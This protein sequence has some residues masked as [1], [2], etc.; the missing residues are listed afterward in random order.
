MDD[1][2]EYSDKLADKLEKRIEKLYEEFTLEESFNLLSEEQQ[3]EA[4]FILQTFSDYMFSYH[5]ELE[6]DWSPD[7]VELCC[8]ETLPRKVSADESYYKAIVPVLDVF[9]E[10]LETK[11]VIS[12]SKDLRK[13]IKSV[14]KDIIRNAADPSCWGLAKGMVMRA[15]SQGYDMFDEDEMNEY[16]EQYNNSLNIPQVKP[17]RSPKKIGRN[18]PCI[19]GSGTKYK[20]CCMDENNDNDAY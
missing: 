13:T 19:C 11:N 5:G 17:Y 6:K 14:E 20:K 10:F 4:S 3:D 8:T 7:N 16:V 18:D 9:F 2:Y 12:N 1:Y 15:Q